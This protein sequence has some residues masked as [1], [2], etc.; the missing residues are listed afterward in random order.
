MVNKVEGADGGCW[1]RRWSET[2]NTASCQ[3][4][5]TGTKGPTPRGPYR[6]KVTAGV[7]ILNRE[8]LGGH[9]RLLTDGAF[10]RRKEKKWAGDTPSPSDTHLSEMSNWKVL[11]AN[12]TT[13]QC[14]Y[15]HTHNDLYDNKSAHRPPAVPMP[16]GAL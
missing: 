13:T 15:T 16:S 6:K 5:N 12:H 11:G 9:G 14:P 4:D 7:D 10:A 1:H 2:I 8:P 3:T